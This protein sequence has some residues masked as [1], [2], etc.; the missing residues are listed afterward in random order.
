VEVDAVP[1]IHHP[2]PRHDNEGPVR[3]GL[4]IPLQGPAGIFGPSCEFCAALAVDHINAEGGLLGREVQLQ[5][6]DGGDAPNR[7]ANEVDRLLGDQQI[8]AIVGWHSSAVRQ[9]VAPRVR[10]RVPYIYTALYEGGEITPGL[11][12]TGETPHRQVLAAL[13]W[14]AREADIS[15]WTIIGDDYVW[16]R[17][18]AAEATAAAAECG[19]TFADNIFVTSDINTHSAALLELEQRDSDGVLMLMLGEHGVQFNRQFVSAGLDESLAR[20]S[21]LMDENMLL[22]SGTNTTRNL[23]STAG[24][25]ETLATAESLDLSARYTRKYGS[26]APVLNSVGESCYEGMLLLAE[27]IGGARSLDVDNLCASA[28]GTIYSSPR[29]EVAVTGQDLEQQVYLAQATGLNFDILTAL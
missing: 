26:D 7:V 23:Y 9:A 17:R 4:L 5:V 18:T 14:L 29:G 10:A 1:S 19:V 25:F 8:D 3:I 12:M 22:A 27:L 11:F 6:V 13:S 15:R 2:F 20:L 24:Y 28:P 21:P 16:P